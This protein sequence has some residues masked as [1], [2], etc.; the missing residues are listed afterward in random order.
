MILNICTVTTNEIN[1]YR[2]QASCPDSFVGEIVA[3]YSLMIFRFAKIFLT[4]R[5]F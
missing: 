3:L 1:S 4:N 5:I 2:V